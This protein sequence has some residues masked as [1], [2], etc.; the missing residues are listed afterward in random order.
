V[1][2]LE[3]LAADGPVQLALTEALNVARL[4]TVELDS[5]AR[6][7]MLVDRDAE[8]YMRASISESFLKQMARYVRRLQARGALE[9]RALSAG[10]DIERWIE[11]FLRLEASGWKGQ[12][13]SALACS[14][15][16]ARF[17]RE[18]FRAAFERG[19]L[20]M[21]GLDLNGRPIARMCGFI[22][23][24]G[25]F[26]FKTAYDEALANCSPGVLVGL[27]WIRRMHEIPQLRW[28]DSY[29]AP[30]NEGIRRVWKGARSV[31]RLAIGTGPRGKLAM[32]ALPLL[33]AAKRIIAR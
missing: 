25:S 13:G 16:N 21:V 14:E 8:S 11:D 33:R 3:Y 9:H 30:G 31:Q 5:Y 1:L 15:E 28:T 7:L 19:R 2:Q 24:E 20:L 29:T 26:A 27:D 17:A 23:G 32:A 6:P 4:P 10:D 12:Q 22:A 18:V